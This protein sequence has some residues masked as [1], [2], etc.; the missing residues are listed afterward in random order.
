MTKRERIGKHLNLEPVDRTPTLGGWLASAEHLQSLSGTTQEEFWRDPTSA[1]INAYQTLDVDGM[2]DIFR[3]PS[4]DRFRTVT[5]EDIEQRKRK[6][7]SPEDVLIYI[8]SLPPPEKIE[9]EFDARGFYEEYVNDRLVKQ[10]QI[11]EIVWMPAIFST[12]CKFMWYNE[13]GY[14]SYLSA[15]ALY[16]DSAEKLFEFSAE[17]ARL[18]NR[19]IAKAIKEHSFMPIILL[20]QDICGTEGPMVSPE[21]LR[22]YYFPHVKTALQPFHT[23]GIK[24]IWHCDGNVLPILDDILDLG[25]HGLQGFQ[26]EKGVRLADLVKRRT[27][28]GQKLIF[29]GSISVSHTL[30]FGTV[31]DVKKAVEYSIDAVGDN[32]TLFLFT[33]NTVNP[34]VPLENIIAMYEHAHRYGTGRC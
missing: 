16:P 21:F 13:F 26:E 4:Q 24:T 17:E 30:P 10:R 12:S 15:L 34:D 9:E 1:I 3:P 5:R 33:A 32:G 23:A 31:E 7:T 25:V 11:G 27:K 28:T 22:R 19:V 6:Y 8:D 29:F 2:I 20:G 18:K 14:E